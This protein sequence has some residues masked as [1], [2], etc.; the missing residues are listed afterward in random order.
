MKNSSRKEL[1]GLTRS[2]KETLFSEK[3][4]GVESVISSVRKEPPREETPDRM[5]LEALSKIVSVCTKCRLHQGRRNTVFGEGNPKAAL[6]FVGE[7]PG[8]DEDIQGRPFV[9]LAGQLLTKIIESIG[10]KRQDVY[11]ANILKCRPPENRPPEPDEVQMCQPYLF[12]QIEEI[13]PKILCVLGRSAATVLVRKEGSI[14]ALRG[15]FTDFQGIP[16]MTTFHPAYLL[17][18]PSAKRLVWEDMKKIKAYLETG[19]F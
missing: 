1:L 5:T 15:Q 11:I 6:M 2:L 9:G 18:N 14:S 13:G 10:L 3:Q 16:V 17:R 4:M 12:A 19:K 7:A 8:R